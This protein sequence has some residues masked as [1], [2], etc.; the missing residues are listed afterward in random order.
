M[1]EEPDDLGRENGG[2]GA[3]RVA[4][5]L[6]WASA[7]ALVT[8]TPG[9]GGSSGADSIVLCLLCGTTASADALLNMALFLPLGMLVAVRFGPT[10]AVLAGVAVSVAIEVTQLLLVPG[11]YPST[12]DIVWNGAG[13]ALGA[14][15]VP[16]LRAGLRGTSSSA[17]QIMAVGIPGAWLIVAGLLLVPVRVNEPYFAEWTPASRFLEHYRG[18]VLHAE[19]NETSV[20]P[21]RFPT[22]A[23]PDG[24]LAGDWTLRVELVKGPPP[25]SLAPMVRLHTEDTGILLLGADGE[26]LV[27]RERM[28]ARVLRFAYSDYSWT[29]ALA[30]AR[31]G[32]TITVGARKTGHDLCLSVAALEHCGIGVGPA[33]SW[34]LLLTTGGRFH[35]REM[36]LSVAWMA[37]LFFLIGLVGGRPT[38]TLVMAGVTLALVAASVSLTPLTP[39]GWTEWSGI[40]LGI[41]S[42][43]MARPLARH[44]LGVAP[45]VSPDPSGAN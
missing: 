13:A 14:G 33:A 16:L 24:I 5:A 44:F 36:L 31:T 43:V 8:L 3:L 34:R 10:R 25:P 38:P 17:A 4:V 22:G 18:E 45:G 1:W 40:S 35:R 29:D 21:G 26:T 30:G 41:S 28:W 19:L 27:W 6:L 20:N 9:M 23:D 12:A 11:R 42:G 2:G 15:V 37:G 39:F 7:V 32:D